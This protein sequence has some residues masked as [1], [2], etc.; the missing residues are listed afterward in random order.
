MNVTYFVLHYISFHF[1]FKKQKMHHFVK[2]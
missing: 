2:I 1:L